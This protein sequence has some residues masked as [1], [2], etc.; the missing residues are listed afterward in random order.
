MI[1]GQVE[2]TDIG[3]GGIIG[4]DLA[5]QLDATGAEQLF[6]RLVRPRHLSGGDQAAIDDDGDRP[7]GGAGA[8]NRPDRRR[9]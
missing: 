1:L 8:E 6:E 4:R 9:E 3:P 5:H 7:C 2:I